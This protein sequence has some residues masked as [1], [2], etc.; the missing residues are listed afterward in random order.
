MKIIGI[1]PGSEETAFALMDGEY[2]V[3]EA[4]KVPN[5]EFLDCVLPCMLDGGKELAVESIQ[6]YGI[7]I[8]SANLPDISA[9]GSA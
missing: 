6:S 7:E 8:R 1:D 5:D 2:T 4:A 9:C 3:L